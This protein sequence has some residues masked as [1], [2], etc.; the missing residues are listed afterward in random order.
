MPFGQGISSK[1]DKR[2]K[3]APYYRKLMRITYS[4]IFQNDSAAL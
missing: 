1:Y 3:R 2:L 4:S